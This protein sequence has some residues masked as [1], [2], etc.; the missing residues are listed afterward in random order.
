M[1]EVTVDLVP[2]P[3]EG[4]HRFYFKTPKGSNFADLNL[5]I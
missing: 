5:E 1:K 4:H 3:P 2:I